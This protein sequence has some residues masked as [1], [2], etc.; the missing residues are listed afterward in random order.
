[1]L[2]YRQLIFWKKLIKK[3]KEE[4]KDKEKYSSKAR[5][6]SRQACT[7]IIRD[8][9]IIIHDGATIRT[10]SGCVSKKPHILVYE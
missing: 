1:M 6:S 3:Q 10:R 7:D 5:N 9:R 8:N 4:A 2:P